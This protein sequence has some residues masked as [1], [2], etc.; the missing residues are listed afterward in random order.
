MPTTPKTQ[1][2]PGTGLM[3]AGLLLAFLGGL[4]AV[5]LATVP[6]HTISGLAVLI[7]V[8]GL[9]LAGVGFA[10]RLLA[11]VEKGRTDD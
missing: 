11:A 8:V 2:R 5:Y 4:I 7:L 6:P 3:K 10:R 9:V 1:A